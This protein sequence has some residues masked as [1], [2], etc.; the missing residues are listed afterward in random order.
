MPLDDEH[1]DL[2]DRIR[3]SPIT[4]ETINDLLDMAIHTREDCETENDPVGNQYIENY[5]YKYITEP[6]KKNWLKWAVTTNEPR[7]EECYRRALLFEAPKKVD[8]YFRF[9]EF[10]D[11]SKF[12]EPRAEYLKPII[13][14]YQDILD[15]KL[16]LLTVSQPKRTGKTTSAITFVTMMAGLHPENGILATGAGEALV[17]VF[18]KTALKIFQ[19]PTFRE[20]FPLSQ[21]RS[22]QSKQ[23]NVFLGDE[24]QM[25]ASL[26]CR[27]ID[28]SMVGSTEAKNL[29]YIDDPVS[30]HEEAVNRNRLDFLA[31]KITGD[32][33]GRRLTGTPILIQGT[34]YSIYDPIGVLIEKAKQVGW[35][36]KV[37]AIPALDPV[38]DESNFD[39]VVDGRHIFTTEFYRNERKIVNE[40]QWSAEFQQEPIEAKGRVFPES[41]LKRYFELPKDKEPDAIIAT[42]DTAEKG[43]DSTSLIIGQIYGDDV[44]ICD[45]V[46]DNSGPD[47]TKPECAEKLIEHKVSNCQFESNN[48]GEYYARDVDQLVKDRGGKCSITTKRSITQKMTRIIVASDGIKQHFYFKDKSL[49]QPGSQYDLFMK[50]L[51]GLT[52]TGKV[53]HDDA[54]DVTAMLENRIR[55]LLPSKVEVIDRRILGF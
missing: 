6:I 5:I 51:T 23:M 13:S 45:V 33:L 19:K 32:V 53:P 39:C 52:K 1:K 7:Y 22:T 30:N 4:V 44:Y 27:P 48:A 34:R 15:G 21:V 47:I 9:I 41:E 31:E 16:D 10:D 20:V 2:I 55:E 37:V 14:A 8:S 40:E 38:T 36:Y 28:G 35:R 26:Q 50:E 29:L 3:R 46:H 17:S 11:N 12:Y 42:C 25:Y 49:Y 24:P 43:S 18:Y 54:P